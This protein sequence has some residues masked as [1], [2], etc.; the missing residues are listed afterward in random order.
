MTSYAKLAHLFRDRVFEVLSMAFLLFMI[1]F[2]TKLG[3]WAGAR[4]GDLGHGITTILFVIA[5]VIAFTYAFRT[6]VRHYQVLIFSLAATFILFAI[7]FADKA[8][9]FIPR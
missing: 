2:G 9:H 1:V 3:E 6:D 5:S 4:Y 8:L 7:Y